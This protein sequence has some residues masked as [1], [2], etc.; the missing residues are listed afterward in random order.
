MSFFRLCTRRR[1][2]PR[3]P[4]ASPFNVSTILVFA[5]LSSTRRVS[6]CS[7][8]TLQGTF[9]PAPLAPVPADGDHHIIR[10]T[11]IVDRLI[12]PLPPS[13]GEGHR[14]TSPKMLRIKRSDR[15]QGRAR[16]LQH[17]RRRHRRAT[18][19]PAQVPARGRGL[20]R[21]IHNGAK[22]AA[23]D[24]GSA[25]RRR[26]RTGGRPSPARSGAQVRASAAPNCR[27]PSAPRIS[28]SASASMRRST[29]KL[30]TAATGGRRRRD[31]VLILR[32]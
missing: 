20:A 1:S 26:L 12:G 21:R 29:P 25:A 31:R 10:E 22:R 5:R 13:C 18:G 16:G 32:T 11:V 19:A 24:L 7:L 8:Q 30:A 9:G 6:N 17:R 3:N 2:N 14:S 4:K 27:P 28:S 15:A 23:V